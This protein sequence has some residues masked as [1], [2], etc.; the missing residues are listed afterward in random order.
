[1]S[2]MNFK[3]WIR[4]P[5]SLEQSLKQ[6]AQSLHMSVSDFVRNSVFTMIT[7]IKETGLD[8]VYLQTTPEKKILK[9]IINEEGK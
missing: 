8:C 4:F 5:K 1:M 6:T 3:V 9:F 7:E 2:G